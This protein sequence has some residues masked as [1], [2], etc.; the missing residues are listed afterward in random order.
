MGI[1]KKIAALLALFIGLMSVFAGSKVLLG[2]VTKDYTVIT[3]L[4]TYN[5]FFGLTSIITAYFLWR[6][7]KWGLV[8]MWFILIAHFV[9]FIY[10]KFISDLA[11]NESKMAMLFRVSIW[12]IIVMMS[13]IIPKYFIKKSK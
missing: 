3:W 4:V 11:A 9:V 2:I 10:L 1:I 12:L 8:M 7:N 13:F 6:K 5:I